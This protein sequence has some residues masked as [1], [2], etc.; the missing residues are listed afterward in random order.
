M[1]LADKTCARV[2][3]MLIKHV[4]LNSRNI[5]T[6]YIDDAAI[7]RD[8]FSVDRWI[9]A[10]RARIVPA[11]SI[12]ARSFV[13][14]HGLEWKL[15]PLRLKSSGHQKDQ[16]RNQSRPVWLNRSPLSLANPESLGKSPP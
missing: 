12:I 9:L 3:E 6:I 15:D 14:S 10:G 2:F 16:F 7:S 5:S 1:V 8:I 4:A 11:C 13:A